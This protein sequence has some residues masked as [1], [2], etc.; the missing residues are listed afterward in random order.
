MQQTTIQGIFFHIMLKKLENVT[1][2]WTGMVGPK[3]IIF[4]YVALYF[5]RNTGKCLKMIF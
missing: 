5:E 3:C 4:I 1:A 2:V